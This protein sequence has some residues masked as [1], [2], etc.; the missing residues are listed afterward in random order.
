M[1]YSHGSLSFPKG[2]MFVG[3]TSLGIGHCP[4]YTGQSG[5][6]LAGASLIRPIFRETTQGSI[7]LT[8]VYELYAPK[9]R[10]TRQ[11]S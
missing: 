10:S 2:G 8:D 5:V 3:R 6:P 7:F 1:N 11:T 4:V 9:K